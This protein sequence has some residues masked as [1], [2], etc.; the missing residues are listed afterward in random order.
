MS[1]E[2]HFQLGGY[3]H[4]QNCCIWGSEN[5]EMIIEKP[6]SAMCNCLVRFLDRRDHWAL[7]F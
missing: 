4:K 1:D 5:P 7:F 6:L 2:A 3:L